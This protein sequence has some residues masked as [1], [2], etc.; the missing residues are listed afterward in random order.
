MAVGGLAWQVRRGFGLLAWIEALPRALH[1]D[2]LWP[3]SLGG[4]EGNF[5]YVV[6]VLATLALVGGVVVY[7]ASEKH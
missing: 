3:T 5:W 4:F 6:P 1:F 7:F 2:A